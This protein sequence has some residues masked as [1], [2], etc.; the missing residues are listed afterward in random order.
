MAFL[1]PKHAFPSLEEA[2]GF[3]ERA[4]RYW[5]DQVEQIIPVH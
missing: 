4:R 1:I 5:R 3:F 2:E